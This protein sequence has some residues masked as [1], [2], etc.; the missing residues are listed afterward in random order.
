M[1]QLINNRYLKFF[2]YS[3][4][5]IS[6]ALGMIPLMTVLSFMLS[7]L[8]HSTFA[9]AIVLALYNIST[10]MPKLYVAKNLSNK[11]SSFKSLLI[12]RFFQ[13][14]VWLA[15][16]TLFFINTG[17]HF[18]IVLFCFLYLI[19]AVIKGSVDVL[20]LDIYSRVVPR[21]NI[22]KFFGYKYSLNSFAEFF[23]A[24]ILLAILAKFNLADNYSVV[25]FVVFILD[26]MSFSI[27]AM[28]K[29][30][31]KLTS[32]VTSGGYG[33]KINDSVVVS[34][35]LVISC[36][37]S[38]E[39]KKMINYIKSYIDLLKDEVRFMVRT[40]SVFASFLKANVIS[41]IGASVA[42]FFI[43]YSTQVLNLTITYISISNILWLI[44]KMVSSVIWGY[45]VDFIGSKYVMM[46]SRI[47]LL[48]SYLIAINLNSVWMFY[49]MIILH[50]ISSAALVIM[51]QNIFIE[52][53]GDKGPLYSAINSVVCMPFFVVM[54]L[55]SS[56]ISENYGYKIA[57]VLSMIPLIISIAY[58]FKIKLKKKK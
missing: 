45:V 54:P 46:G 40:D 15:M 49:L 47:A 22:G 1:T 32:E 50:G 27:L 9:Y 53:S 57:F 16:S 29:S 38:E 13:L 43:P 23:G 11:D 6:S 58:M 3:E 35:G 21:E 33:V 18:Y 55:L 51:G 48:L 17:E 26:I 56:F 8:S 12:L 37:N 20:A 36:T 4:F 14:M 39:E 7:T 41:I 5:L 10:T 25:F 44:S 30:K 31:V 28:M 52:L 42:S 34:N 24:V 19:Y 2:Y